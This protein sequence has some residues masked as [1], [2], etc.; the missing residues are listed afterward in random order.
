MMNDEKFRMRKVGE[1][2]DL[3]GCEWLKLEKVSVP[4]SQH[5]VSLHVSTS[6]KFIVLACRGGDK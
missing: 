3:K 1:I 2:N 5:H 6:A 4:G